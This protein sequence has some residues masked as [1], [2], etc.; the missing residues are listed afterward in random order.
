MTTITAARTTAA[1]ASAGRG[2]ML[3]GLL[4]DVGGSVGAYY[5]LHALG[6]SDWMALLAAAAVA[7]GRI[8]WVAL[9]DRS[10]NAFASV[11]LVVWGVGLALSF[12]AGDARFLL[13]K[14]SVT[15][16][17][18]GIAFLVSITMGRP[19]TLA[20]A[21]SWTPGGA[22]ELEHLFRTNPA[23]KHAFDVSALVW[24]IGLLAESLVRIP[25][26]YALPVDV[27]VGL[28]T[29]IMITVVSALAI[30]NARYTARVQ[31][32]AEAA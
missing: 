5:A 21:K 9:R 23:A 31:R 29:A 11:M 2:A 17:A 25:L 20:A 28:S 6:A 13:L 18:I 22:A 8:A 19:L 26:V 10:L 12:V 7:G 32:R 15:T 4:W 3:S 16:A 30:W 1:P 27:M 24:G 14:D